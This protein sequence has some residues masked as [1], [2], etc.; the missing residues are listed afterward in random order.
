M[1][2]DVIAARDVLH[3]R[4]QKVLSEE[5]LAELYPQAVSAPKVFLGF[6]TT[7]PPF[8]AAVD[9]VAEGLSTT[10]A[11]SMAHATYEFDLH[12]WLCA[13]H[14]DLQKASDTLLCYIDAVVGSVMADQQLGMTVDNAFPRVESIGTAADDSRRYIAAA[15]V[16]VACT[17]YSA[18]PAALVEAVKASNEGSGR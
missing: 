4:V 1:V 12:V 6:P 7:E 9:E 13:Q 16:A 11:V 2:A 8:Y 5:V 10:G 3:K 17:V 18:C 15:S 14:V